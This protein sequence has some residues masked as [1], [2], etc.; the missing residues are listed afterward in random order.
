VRFF[1][2]PPTFENARKKIEEKKE[3]HL[4]SNVANKVASILNNLPEL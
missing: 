3:A 1:G 4:K 2:N